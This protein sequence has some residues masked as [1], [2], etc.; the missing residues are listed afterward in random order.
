[1]RTHGSPAIGPMSIND[2]FCHGTIGKQSTDDVY[3]PV[4]PL[5][6]SWFSQIQYIPHQ[7]VFQTGCCYESQFDS[8]GL[9]QMGIEDCLLIIL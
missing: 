9:D 2:V 7:N 3:G 6:I 8:N 4:H 5:V 1:M